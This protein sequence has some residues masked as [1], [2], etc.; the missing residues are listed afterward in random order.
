[1]V[2]IPLGR[3][4]GA[5]CFVRNVTTCTIQVECVNGELICFIVVWGFN[6]LYSCMPLCPISYHKELLLY[7]SNHL[8]V[9]ELIYST[10]NYGIDIFCEIANN[11]AGAC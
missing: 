8:F 2:I 10:K 6:A 1:M 9:A 7:I 11:E 3:V 5:F 4:H